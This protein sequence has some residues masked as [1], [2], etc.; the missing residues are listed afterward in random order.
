[1]TFVQPKSLQNDLKRLQNAYSASSFHASTVL[2]DLHDHLCK[3]LIAA[4]PGIGFFAYTNLKFFAENLIFL[5]VGSELFLGPLGKASG[6]SVI[7]RRALLLAGSWVLPEV[8]VVTL[9][10]TLNG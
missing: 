2:S 6:N 7:L 1:M 10:S 3:M 4:P 9:V 5:I 8:V